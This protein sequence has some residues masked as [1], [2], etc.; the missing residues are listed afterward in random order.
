MEAMRGHFTIEEWNIL[1]I[2]RLISL[3]W[4]RECPK[5]EYQ[6]TNEIF[7]LFLRAMEN[8]N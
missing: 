2:Y 6:T 8:K 3:H 4:I 7:E 5:I 1:P